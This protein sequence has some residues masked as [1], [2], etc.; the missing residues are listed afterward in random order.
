MYKNLISEVLARNVCQKKK[1]NLHMLLSIMSKNDDL[2]PYFI[3]Y[4]KYFDI[5]FLLL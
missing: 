1:I 2:R 5:F 4:Q 3:F